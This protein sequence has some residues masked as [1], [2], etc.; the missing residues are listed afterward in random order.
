MRSLIIACAENYLV[1][2]KFAQTHS[3]TTVGV[4]ESA[5]RSAQFGNFVF[6]HTKFGYQQITDYI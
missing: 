2:P 3:K 6:F 1:E 4:A 5:A